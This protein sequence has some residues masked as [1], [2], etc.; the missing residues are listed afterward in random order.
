MLVKPKQ[1]ISERCVYTAAQKSQQRSQRTIC[2][3][4]KYDLG[5][6]RAFQEIKFFKKGSH[7]YDARCWD[8]ENGKIY[9]AAEI[10]KKWRVFMLLIFLKRNPRYFDEFLKCR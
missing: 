5:E 9:R 8:F 4:I 2:K 6:I 3:A 7:F 10:R 1:A